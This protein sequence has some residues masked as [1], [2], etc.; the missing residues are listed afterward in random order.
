MI[1]RQ[2]NAIVTV[3]SQPRGKKP[4]VPSILPE[5]PK[6]P[7]EIEKQDLRESIALFLELHA[8]DLQNILEETAVW[9]ESSQTITL[10]VPDDK[11]IEMLYKRE[12]LSLEEYYAATRW[13]SRLVGKTYIHSV[14]MPQE[15]QRVIPLIHTHIMGKQAR[16]KI[17]NELSHI[18]FRT[19]EANNN[20]LLKKALQSNKMNYLTLSKRIQE[21]SSHLPLNPHGPKTGYKF[22]KGQEINGLP[23]SFSLVD[24]GRWSATLSLPEGNFT[25]RAISHKIPDKDLVAL[26]QR[27]EN[28]LLNFAYSCI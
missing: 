3:P 24:S 20:H 9:D 2:V 28:A 16:I 13:T 15:I 19:S 6:D 17:D 12:H 5:I 14:D 1:G 7:K 22:F 8:A 18:G 25:F 4:P 10:H 21:I 11:L 27:I 26:T 23:Q